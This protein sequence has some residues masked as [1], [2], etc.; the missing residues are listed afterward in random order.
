MAVGS[1]AKA[2][3][4]EPVGTK[5][6]WKHKG[7]QLP[8]Y[9]QHIA[10]ELKKKGMTESR[11]IATAIN[12]VKRW[13]R[14]GGNVKPETRAAALKAVAEWEALKAKAAASRAA[15]A[16]LSEIEDP[17]VSLEVD[18]SD[19]DFQKYSAENLQGGFSPG[20]ANVSAEDYQKLLPLLRYYAKFSHPFA[21]CFADYKEEF[22][23]ENAQRYAGII[24]DLIY[25]STA[26]RKSAEAES[27]MKPVVLSEYFDWTEEEYTDLAKFVESLDEEKVET[28]LSESA[29]R[30]NLA[31]ETN[32]Q[33]LQ[34]VADAAL[35]YLKVETDDSDRFEMKDIF[36]RIHGLIAKDRADKALDKAPH[37]ARAMGMSLSD[38]EPWMGEFFFDDKTARGEIEL[39]A[40]K[41]GYI[42][43]TIMREGRWKLSPGPGQRPVSK[44]I[45]VIAKGKSDPA[46]LVISMSELLKNYEDGAVEH[47]TIPTSHDNKVLENTGFI[48]GL[49]LKKDG[50]GRVT[51]QAAHD[52]TEPDVKGK[53]QNGTIA[54]TSAGVLFDYPRK[55]DGKR[56]NAVLEHVALTNRPWLSGMKPFGMAATDEEVKTVVTFSEEVT[57]ISDEELEA[58]LA[59]EKPEE[60][61]VEKTDDGAA[62]GKADVELSDEEKAP[63]GEE[64]V[65]E[66]TEV[67]EAEEEAAAEETEESEE[68]AD[69]AA[70]PKKPYGD[71]KYADPGYQ[72]DGK[73]RYPLDTEQHCR[74][75][76]SY[77][78][79]AQNAA[80]Y[81][82][83]QLS[84]I[85]ARIRAALKKYG[86]KVN[87]S[88]ARLTRENL[89]VLLSQEVTSTASEGGNEMPDEA[90]VDYVETFG[91]SEDEIRA[92]LEE[93]E[94]LK[95]S[96]KKAKVEAKL[97]E[98]AEEK[99]APAILAAAEA[100]MLADDGTVIAEV[101][102]SKSEG[103]ITLS[104]DPKSKT[105]G[106]TLS[107]V[108]EALVD[109]S[110]AVNLEDK[111]VTDKDTTE[112]TKPEETTEE[113]ELSAD[114]QRRARQLFLEEG[115]S[116]DEAVAKAEA[117]AKAEKKSE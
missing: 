56:F 74:A 104:D 18:L 75:A 72:K 86:V 50:K 7:W 98:W 88:D 66:E 19:E 58:M 99:K 84:K 105:T 30:V 77:I 80:Q 48:R 55:E 76:W 94:A 70:D 109:L 62:E 85:K 37:P 4:H 102:G 53:A 110:G 24:K 40:D 78:N 93:R 92:A 9:I 13:A 116:S 23:E 27:K 71:V 36:R 21:Q 12:T 3:I 87:M 17:I 2:T 31:A 59:E 32:I 14:G 15:K 5:P 111:Q 63:E 22:G 107:D 20:T 54:N 6:L 29:E 57:E 1:L 61:E 114:V 25:H 49:R 100:F 51:L 117:E 33:I 79:Q 115:L 113:V 39:A 10:N 41:D 42:W 95:E 34:H 90:T 47:V 11:A 16:R 43:K 91:L 35:S 38:D 69:L 28:L 89:L 68:K 112:G 60:K 97:S 65:A 26:W 73:K 83:G 46:K 106:L 45:T 82:S 103:K 108:V 81:S 44:P 96:Q 52:F 64:V 67:T 8:A 101:P